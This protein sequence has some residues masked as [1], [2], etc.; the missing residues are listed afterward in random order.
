MPFSRRE[1]FKLGMAS[2]GAGL[3]PGPVYDFLEKPLV[4]PGAWVRDLSAY[5]NL[6]PTPRFALP[7]AG[8]VATITVRRFDEQSPLLQFALN[9]RANFRWV[10]AP[11]NEIRLR[12]D[13]HLVIE[14]DVPEVQTSY[15]GHAQDARWFGVHNDL[16]SW[17][18][19][20]TFEYPST[21]DLGPDWVHGGPH[22]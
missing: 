20:D 16:W 4:H 8:Q 6:P 9:T 12:P 18:E 1:L 3:V 22:G 13:E 15:Y 21:G 10:A 19:P 5:W 17:L 2:L 11:G 14:A 7:D